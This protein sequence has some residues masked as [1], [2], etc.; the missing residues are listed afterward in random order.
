MKIVFNRMKLISLE[1]Y[2]GSSLRKKMQFRK[3]DT[4]DILI[5]TEIQ[6]VL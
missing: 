3:L 4:I 2:G 1:F 5:P 6:E